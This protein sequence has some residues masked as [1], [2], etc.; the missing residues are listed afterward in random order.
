MKKRNAVL[1]AEPEYEEEVLA[2]GHA[3]RKRRI[4]LPLQKVISGGQ[5]GADQ[6]A[7]IA[8][9][10][11]SIDTGGV[12]PRGFMT[13]SGPDPELGRRYKLE[14]LAVDGGGTLTL[15]QQYCV[16]SQRNVD[17][18]DATLAFLLKPSIGT[19]KTIGYCCARQWAVEPKMRLRKP[20]RQCLVITRLDNPARIA[21][22]IVEFIKLHKIKTLNVCGHR[23]D[24]TAGVE[25]FQTKVVDILMRVFS[26]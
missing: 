17:L 25:Q 20:Y 8:A 18:S 19:A 10:A 24:H 16:R 5:T 21:A 23:D 1:T 11:C 2:Q 22:L 26:E 3:I 9:F 4:G 15:A 14:E 7:L 6:A 12:A 13:S